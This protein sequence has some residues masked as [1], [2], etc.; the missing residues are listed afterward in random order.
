MEAGVRQLHLRLHTHGTGDR[1]V[2]PRVD[3]VFQQR[4]LPDPRLTVQ[5]KRPA[6]APAHRCQ[7]LVEQRTFLRASKQDGSPTGPGTIHMCR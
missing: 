3:Q 5:G 1:K 7:Q 6:L 2:R 4:R